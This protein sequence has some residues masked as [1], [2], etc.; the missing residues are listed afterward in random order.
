MS[1]KEECVGT[2]K[3]FGQDDHFLTGDI[4]F[5]QSFAYDLFGSA[6]GINVGLGNKSAIGRRG[7]WQ[8]L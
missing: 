4:V 3:A 1:G 2:E 6:I 5:L 8:W 7:E